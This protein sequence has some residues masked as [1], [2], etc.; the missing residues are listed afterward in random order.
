V[1]NSA[2]PDATQAEQDAALAALGISPADIGLVPLSTT[3]A[4]LLP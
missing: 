3:T 1:G 4:G 2:S